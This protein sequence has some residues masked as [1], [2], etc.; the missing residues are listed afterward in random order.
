M[1]EKV[2][3]KDLNSVE[4]L[5]ITR[6][7][8]VLDS[9]GNPALH[10][11]EFL[12]T[13]NRPGLMSAE[14]KKRID[15]LENTGPGAD[16]KVAQ[17]NT[18][19]S[20]V[21]RLLFS[22]T[23]TDETKTE[24]AR[25]S[26]KLTFNPSTGVLQTTALIGNLDGTYVNKLT[27]YNKATNVAAI[28]AVDSL[29][30]AL[31]KL[32]LK[33]DVV[34]NLVKGAYDG[35]GTIENLEEIL[36]VLEG[37]SDTE[38][39]QAIIGK[40]LPLTGGT[41]TGNISAPAYLLGN[42]NGTYI[43]SG[44]DN[45]LIFYDN[46]A[47]R[48]VIHS[49]N[50]SQQNVAGA[51]KLISQYVGDLN[52][53]EADRFFTSGFQ[54][55]NRPSHHNYATG[56]SLYNS[57]L[58]YK[59]Q[60]TFDTYGTLYTR[61]LNSSNTWS[62]WNQIA[63]IANIPTLISQLTDDLGLIH[64]GNIQNQTV[65]AAKQ[66]AGLYVGDNADANSF[67]HTS[68]SVIKF[69]TAIGN[70]STNFP[71]FASWQNALLEIG[72]HSNGSTAQF[73]FSKDNPLYYRSN[74]TNAWQQI[75]YIS[76]IPTKL[77]QLTNDSGYVTGGPYLPL[78][79]G[80]LS[81][82]TAYTLSINRTQENPL[83][84]FY[85]NKKLVGF[86]GIQETG[87]PIYVDGNGSTHKI[88]HTGNDGSGSGLDADLLDGQHGS[89]YA[90]ASS[91]ENYL[92]LTGGTLSNNARN[93]LILHDTNSSTSSRGAWIKFSSAGSNNYT[94]IGL[95]TT[96]GTFLEHY[97][98]TTP[99]VLKIDNNGILY[100]RD[101][102]VL[103]AGNYNSYAPKLDGTGATGTWGINISGTAANADALDGY[104][105]SYAS[106]KPYGTIPVITTTGYMDVGRHFEFHYDNTTGSDYSTVLMCTGNYSNIVNLPSASGTLALTSQI[107]TSL[108]ANGGNADTVDNLHASD[109]FR[110]YGT[111]GT[112]NSYDSDWGQSIVT[113]DPVVNGT[114]PES[115]P[116][117]TILNLGN[118]Y[119]RRKQLAFNYNNDNIYFRRRLDSSWKPWVRLALASDI[120]TKLSQLT[121][122]SGYVTG[123]P[124]LPLSGGTLTGTLNLPTNQY[125]YHGTYGINM[126]NSDI[127]GVNSIVM[128]D[129]SDDGNEGIKFYRDATHVDSIWVNS[130]KL[131]FNQNMEVTSNGCV[132]GT[133][134]TVAF[135]S[136]I[137][138][139]TNYYWADQ[140]ITDSAINNSTPTFG[141]TT[142]NYYKY[143]S[144]GAQLPHAGSDAW[145]NVYQGTI[146]STGDTIILNLSHSYW[147][148]NTDAVSL[149][150]TVGHDN[151]SINQISA[152]G[153]SGIFKKARVRFDN[154][155]VWVD[156]LIYSHTAT[157]DTIYVSGL[158][159]GNFK[160]P[161]ATSD[162]SNT[163]TEISIFYSGAY[164]TSL[165]TDQIRG[166]F[167][168]YNYNQ[169][170][171]PAYLQL[172]RADTTVYT[173]R[174]CIGITDGNLHIDAY[175]NKDIYL[176][177]YQ[178]PGTSG[179]EST[180]VVV[181]PSGKVGIGTASPAHKLD[182][183]GRIFS[184]TSDVDGI[185][186]KRQAAGSGAF[187]RYLSDNQDAKG[188]R[189][190]MLGTQ[191][192]F[193]FEYSTDTFGSVSQKL[194]ILK[195]G[196]LASPGHIII[197]GS[198]SNDMTYD[199]NVHGALCFE[200]SDSSQNIRF[201]FTDYDS[202]RSPAGIKLV[203][204][205]GGE[206]FEVGGQI[207]ASGG[208]PVITSVAD[209]N[210]YPALLTPSGTNNW[211]RVSN[212]S[213]YGL[214]PNQSGGAG[215]GHSYLGTSSWYFKYA[216]IDQIYGYLNG[217][218][219]GNAAYAASAGNA[220]TVDGYHASSLWRS[221]GGT[222]NPSANILLNATANGQEWS[223]DITR[224]G[225]TGCYWHVWDSALGTMLKVNADDGKVSA[226][227]GFVGNLSGNATYANSAG[228]TTRLYANSAGDLLTYPGDYSLSYSRFQSNA[229][230]IFPVSNNAN[231]CITAHLHSGDYY[232]QI[233]LSSNGRMYYRTMMAQTLSAGVGWKTV[234]WTSDIP[235][236]VSQ[237]TNDSGFVTGG[238][239]LPLS[240]GT[241]S[242]NLTI[243][244]N[245][246]LI[247][248]PSSC[249]Y[250][251]DSGGT[252]RKIL[253]LTDNVM[254][255]GTTTFA[256]TI[257]SNGTIT[258]VGSVTAT[259][260]YE[261]SDQTL[262]TNIQAILDSDNMP[263]IKS[264]DWK[265]D[266]TH[267]YGLIAQELEEQG[268]SELV[269]NEGDHKT[270][271][272]SAAL[273]LIVGKL[274]N[275]I[276][277]LEAEIENLKLRA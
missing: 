67:Y 175:K 220:D 182:V 5:P 234:A 111:L 56:I 217:N 269:S 71:V 248:K 202:Y 133:N 221:D 263:V 103:H 28:E 121:N 13:E 227:Y 241:M 233:G 135:T 101:K 22:E 32:E 240:G 163:K 59:Y 99:Y 74:Y 140:L 102:N 18:T 264:F 185:I 75:A 238:P 180:A 73:Y 114:Y 63:G 132:G 6:G 166:P 35:D 127:I 62:E 239:Y 274:Q 266:G 246:N 15:D 25:K 97:V 81:G 174:G 91:L 33:A 79:G 104:H 117:V 48:T 95:N 30:T 193:T 208:Y 19:T 167:V 126:N 148:T 277:E 43:D 134:K 236:K 164:F 57:E 112:G 16:N 259:H 222:W 118:N 145:Y 196:G 270:V 4:I 172:G 230:N 144:F 176:N 232:A 198:T 199:G 72:L 258:M 38:T 109:L 141:T 80:T 12:A 267:S 7:E 255:V 50:I 229:S 235:T 65:L 46:T 138:T 211:I 27:G 271:N 96:T 184:L 107:P 188:W 26:A 153:G 54:A 171:S 68:E 39:I 40:Y 10:S 181:K 276:K 154:T 186:I 36:R 20:D 245:V 177:Y 190:G 110:A 187:V 137:P 24:G 139:V 170:L 216:Y 204:N 147:Y 256:T 207:Y 151:A 77:S 152:T 100:F 64:T 52:G 272:Y 212:S 160:T 206:W 142:A 150:I 169:W 106:N 165:K 108:P 55:S 161:T 11:N 225:K 120:P 86:L 69:R 254:Q 162:S 155:T 183:R 247:L 41:L 192:D 123:G 261:S 122:D 210:G 21:Y 200:N 66:L 61:Y 58:K 113:F 197:K 194:C 23:A 275:K 84:A 130:G 253:R 128:R 201:I 131:Y 244:A 76:D 251:T 29:N 268:Y 159:K 228:Y 157:T 173:D 53:A 90:A 195:G 1:A 219:S 85:A 115:N 82:S 262:K 178:S 168:Q 92:P 146:N 203:G 44:A 98:D 119:A 8:L 89:Y 45:T 249:I 149:A 14:D 231:G 94:T 88:W 158:G 125:H 189:V 213:S 49:G 42:G 9:S 60:L 124:Y 218:I 2:I 252:N 250:Y 242:G 129:L 156:V 224:N 83:I 70:N 205:Q 116:N 257:S 51:N 226:P 223:F 214:L 87:Y 78:S 3:L 191:N 243:G 215:S 93:L 34:Y 47:R 143:K 31:G 179:Q 37:I 260:F 273:S 17:V 237:L 265:S 209:G 136:D 105:A